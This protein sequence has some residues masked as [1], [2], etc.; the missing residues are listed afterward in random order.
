LDI[1]NLSHRE[2]G[3][4]FSQIGEL[5]HQFHVC[6]LYVTI[7]VHTAATLTA[8]ENIQWAGDGMIS[9]SGNRQKLH[10]VTSLCRYASSFTDGSIV[11]YVF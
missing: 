1:S 3:K 9:V 8:I 4:D 6:A 11:H 2:D 7:H 5:C 10:D